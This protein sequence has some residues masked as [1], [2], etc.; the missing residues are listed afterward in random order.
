MRNL[1]MGLIVVLMLVGCGEDGVISE[2]EKPN[3]LSSNIRVQRSKFSNLFSTYRDPNRCRNNCCDE[4]LI[5]NDMKGAI[6]S[7]YEQGYT[8]EVK[9]DFFSENEMKLNCDLYIL[10]FEFSQTKYCKK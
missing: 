7:F 10:I 9:P 3:E 5:W 4:E 1:I 2:V 6:I 8:C